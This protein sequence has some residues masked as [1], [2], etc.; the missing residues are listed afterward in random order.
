MDD[1][2]DPGGTAVPLDGDT[3]MENAADTDIPNDLALP[4]LASVEDG[5]QEAA[6]DNNPFAVAADT[7]SVPG[8][9]G[10]P[11]QAD[12][13]RYNAPENES[14][15]DQDSSPSQQPNYQPP[16]LRQIEV[17]LTPPA[18]PELYERLPPSFDVERVLEEVELDEES[19]Y[20]V[21]FQDGRVD[22]VPWDELQ[23]MPN[24]R[25][26]IMDFQDPDNFS[27]DSTIM[28]KIKETYGDKDEDSYHS[29]S[30]SDFDIRPTQ[31][32]LKTFKSFGSQRSRLPRRSV[33][34]SSRQTSVENGINSTG[35]SNGFDDSDENEDE[36]DDDVNQPR[37]KANASATPSTA[38]RLTRSK[39]S[40]LPKPRFAESEDELQR[41]AKP[42]YDD[43]DTDNNDNITFVRSD[44]APPTRMSS[45]KRKRPAKGSYVASR[46]DE[47]DSSIGFE[48]N[49]RSQR[50]TRHSKTMQDPEIDDD[51]AVAEDKPDAA[52]KTASIK[53]VF[54]P[55]PADS[56]FGQKHAQ[57]CFNCHEGSGPDSGPGSTRGPFI[58]CQG[59]SYAFHQ[60]CIG[61]R[62]GRNHQV[63]KIGE[64]DFVLQC[65][66]CINTHLKQNKLGP[67]Y[68]KCQ[69]CKVPGISCA[70]FSQKKTPKQEE[71]IRL[72]NGGIDPITEVDPTL[73][74]N[75]DAV[76]FRCEEC[77]R[78]YHPDH[79]PLSTKVVSDEIDEDDATP[80]AAPRTCKDCVDNAAAGRK[81]NTLVAWRPVDQDGYSPGQTCN[82]IPLDDIE[83]L[84]KWQGLSYFHVSWMPGAWVYGAAPPTMRTS[85]HKRDTAAY[86]KM[87]TKAAVEDDWLL[88][89]VF[90]KVKYRDKNHTHKSKET[91]LQLIDDIEK[92]FVKFQGLTYDD[93][94][95]DEPPPRD[96]GG[97]WTT[98]C[99]AYDEY[100]NGIYFP[101]EEE[102]GMQARVKEYRSLDF[103]TDCC[104][105][106][107]PPQLQ[108]GNLMEYQLEGVNFMLF[109]YHQQKN[110]ILADEMGLG[111][112][113]QII[114]FITSL[115][116]NQ[117][118]VW[119][120]LIVVPNSTCP[121]WRRELK[122]WAPELRV[123]TYHGGQHPQKLAYDYELFPRDSK[124][125]KAHVV[126]MS[127]DS[128]AT[129]PTNSKFKSVKWA[130]LIVDEG[131]RLKNEETYL[132]KALAAMRIPCR[133]LLTGTPLQ[134]NKKELFNLL[135]FI[136]YS[137]DAA[138]LD[139]KYATLTKENVPELH[140]LIRPYFLRRTKKQVLKFLPP[141][142]QIIL[143]V[144][145]TLLQQKL[146]KSIMARNPE[147]IRAIVSNG[148]LGKSDRKSLTNIF[149]DLRQ[150]LCH[151]FCFRAE[152]ED[153]TVD[154]EQMH[155]NLVEASSKLILLNYM[156]PKLKER[157]HRVL[158]FSQFLHCLTIIED[159]LTGL[160]LAHARIDGSL[161]AAEKQ[162]RIDAFNADDS[163]LFVMLLSTRAG[164]V[165]INLATADT[166]IIYDPDFNPHQDIQALSRAHRIGQKKK[167]LCFQLMTKN[168]IEEKIMQIGRQKMALDH[169]LI[170]SLDTKKEDVGEDLETILKHGA[171]ALFDENA[172]D[173]ITYDSASVDKLLDRSQIEDTNAGDDESAETQFSFARVW[174]NDKGTLNANNVDDAAA[175][176]TEMSEEARSSMWA[177][178]LKARE[179][180]H[181]RKLA[182]EQ[183]EYGRGARR[184][185]NAA[186]NYNVTPREQDSA[187][188]ADADEL[189]IDQGDNNDP[190]EEYESEGYTE[191]AP[192]VRGKAPDTQ[193]A[194]S[195]QQPSTQMGAKTPTAESLR[196]NAPSM[197]KD[198]GRPSQPARP[199]ANRPTPNRPATQAQPTQAPVLPSQAP[200]RRQNPNFVVSIPRR[201]DSAVYTAPG[202]PPAA[203]RGAP[204][205]QHHAPNGFFNRPI[206]NDRAVALPNGIIAANGWVGGGSP[207]FFCFT[208]HY[209]SSPCLDLHAEVS[210]RMALDN[211]RISGNA[212]SILSAK[213]FLTERLRL[214]T[215]RKTQNR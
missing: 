172:Q 70:Q 106:A 174:A 69:A 196:L 23:R 5:G 99:E 160:G 73:I 60:G 149:A 65:R 12:E 43:D 171:A 79:W 168:S 44:L 138:K 180:E 173:E 93:A 161:S 87:D 118:R 193:A 31:K 210:I 143:P 75:A 57:V 48:P 205:V 114:A 109:N 208:T 203:S 142:A 154:G 170:E 151:P 108:R 116:Q 54:K 20:S 194:S 117:P 104:L 26:A 52:T 179:E 158:I 125:M 32:R 153:K 2:V 177:N 121:N 215:A 186:T 133:I 85:F 134:N 84:V 4:D 178:I 38:G 58:Y 82:D 145:M 136:D 86:P 15:S 81:A 90:F 195:N 9:M 202:A 166:V 6:S 50:S 128:A 33:R 68:S 46:Y 126:I 189:Y 112:T 123:V 127:Y 197:T 144:T 76:L 204:N 200:L 176:D 10:N 89:D 132:Y 188:E 64:D 45:R 167:V 11:A 47:S 98:F 157:G 42:D 61:Y 190:E 181:Q 103:G 111:K 124:G 88:A 120:F 156:L 115:A 8:T 36:S 63:T 182:A 100:L 83:Y 66:L 22:Q 91:D 211:L 130:A 55:L 51:Y 122:R 152:V 192:R 213:N 49:R 146:S 1:T 184:R 96:S 13:D 212:P 17:V 131:Q 34:R 155:R 185:T 164:G 7:D 39:N 62:G 201:A 77:K 105:R 28:V 37:S 141:M 16:R 80:K 35:R 97:P 165:G 92:V 148:K 169:V 162:K 101:T 119:P 207:C 140:E 40:A 187:S 27:L 19:W 206:P 150:C 110:V 159:F 199:N 41:P 147:L 183:K 94:V 56:E 198:G 209:E 71:K 67:D 95:W 78:A 25:Q 214:I 175:V 135:Q 113:V 139:A 53:E 59:C 3:P 129:V 191:S 107:Q 72:E 30:A 137:Q 29:E 74:N 21:E 14:V 163:P 102:S 18:E 24:G